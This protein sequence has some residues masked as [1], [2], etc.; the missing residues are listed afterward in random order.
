MEVLLSK[1]ICERCGRSRVWKYTN[2]KQKNYT[3]IHACRYCYVKHMRKQYAKMYLE[4]W[5]ESNYTRIT[6]NE[7]YCAIGG[8]MN[9]QKMQA[10]MQYIGE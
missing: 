9:L 4:C 1:D 2:T 7:Q 8:L 6:V 10:R 3:S 5:G